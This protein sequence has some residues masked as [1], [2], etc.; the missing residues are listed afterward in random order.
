[1][2]ARAALSSRWIDCGLQ[3]AAFA[4]LKQ[5]ALERTEVARLAF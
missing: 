3:S 4:A 1:M 2:L 5:K